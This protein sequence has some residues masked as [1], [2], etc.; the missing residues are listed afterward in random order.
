[1]CLLC[2]QERLVPS[3]G[4]RRP[5]F[6]SEPKQFEQTQ[7]GRGRAIVEVGSVTRGWSFFRASVCFCRDVRLGEECWS[8]SM[9][10]LGLAS[11]KP[12]SF[13]VNCNTP[14]ERVLFECLCVYICVYKCVYIYVCVC[15]CA[16]HFTCFFRCKSQTCKVSLFNQLAGQ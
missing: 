2:C 13:G 9:G 5:V 12:L 3:R 6:Y 10:S 16:P 14:L 8:E 4:L 7:V 11:W 15:V 1:M